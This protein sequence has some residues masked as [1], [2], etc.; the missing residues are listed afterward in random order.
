MSDIFEISLRS[1]NLRWSHH[2][3]VSS[4]KTIEGAIDGKLK[5]SSE[6]DHETI[7]DFLDQ[8]AKKEWTVAELKAHVRQ[9]KEVG[10]CASLPFD[11]DTFD[12]E[13]RGCLPQ[14]VQSELTAFLSLTISLCC[15]NV[16]MPKVFDH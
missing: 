6:T 11:D 7:A 4:L 9:H 10:D 13:T 12:L 14:I 3:E 2:K 5:L 1:E 15:P 8:A 16:G